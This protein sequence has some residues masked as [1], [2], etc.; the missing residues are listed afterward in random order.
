MDRRSPIHPSKF[1]QIVRI[2]TILL[3]YAQ[4]FHNSTTPRVV[5][6][7]AFAVV[8]A[9]SAGAILVACDLEVDT[10]YGPHSGLS[11][12]NLPT[13]GASDAVLGGDGGLSCGTP[14]DGGACS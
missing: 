2:R 13:P 12:N 14:V 3:R 7:V 6:V 10:K 1:V 4:C 8:V 9:A 5:A 11:K